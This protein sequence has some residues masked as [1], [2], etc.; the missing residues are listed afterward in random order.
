MNDKSSESEPS[1]GGRDRVVHLLFTTIAI[2]VVFLLLFIFEIKTSFFESLYFSN[3]SR[4]CSFSLGNGPSSSI[5]FPQTG[6]YDKRLGYTLIPDFIKRLKPYGFSIELQARI[7]QEMAKIFDE[8]LNMPYEEKQQAGIEVLDRK[9]KNLFLFK[10]PNPQLTSFDSIPEMIVKALLFIEDRN[11]LDSTHSH[12]NPAMNWTRFYYAMISFVESK[13]HLKKTV[14]G[15]STLA[16]QMEKYRHS[17]KGRTENVKDKLQQMLSASLLAYRDGAYTLPMRKSILLDYINTA[18][19]GARPAFGEVFG[20]SEG[21]SHWYKVRF[22][23]INA[24]LRGDSAPLIDQANAFRMVLGL[25]LAHRK[26]EYFLVKNST[27]LSEETDCY[28]RLFRQR[29]LF[30]DSLLGAAIAAGT[31]HR[32][33]FSAETHP[34]K[35]ILLKPANTVL[36]P[37]IKKLRLKDIYDLVHLDCSVES[38]LDSAAVTQVMTLFQQLKSRPELLDSLGLRAAHLLDLGNPADVIYSLVLFERKDNTNVVRIQADSHDAP[39]DFNSG[40]K[41]DLGS[42]AKLR[43]L[44]TY[45]EIIEELYYRHSR[46]DSVPSASDPLNDP[47]ASWV[48]A[49]LKRNPAASCIDILD[50]SLNRLYSANPYEKFFT[51]GGLHHFD[52]FDKQDD[53]RILSVREAFAHSVNLVFIRLMRDI[54]NHYVALLPDYESAEHDSAEIAKNHYLDLFIKYESVNLLGNFYRQLKKIPASEMADTLVDEI[55]SS[56]SRLGV[57][58]CTVAVDPSD[59]GMKEFF[60]RHGIVDTSM[61]FI[62]RLYSQC[63][64]FDWADRGY[65]AK[66]HPLK[67]WAASCLVK[68]P[69][70]NFS[71]LKSSCIPYLYEMYKWIFS[72]ERIAFQ[73]SRI[74]IMQEMEAFDALLRSWQKLGYPF[75]EIT[76]SFASAIGASADRPSA[77]A[78]LAGIIQNDGLKCPEKRIEKIR[79]AGQTPYET[80][81][82]NADT[83]SCERVL[84]PEVADRVR[85]CMFDV[86][87]DGTAVYASRS[88]DSSIIVGGK[89]GTGDHR[90]RFF[91]RFGVQ[92]GEKVVDRAATFV[93]IIDRRFFGTITVAVLGENAKDYDFTSAYPVRLFSLIAPKLVSFLQEK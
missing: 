26:P 73:K 11:L 68:N 69:K 62:T 44:V 48:T 12:M 27:A 75:A 90:M 61:A 72:P 79:F 57:I 28:L 63:K 22:E 19:L 20:L 89:T 82:I 70:T 41:L 64:A 6:P 2:I 86:I 29:G 5:R 9:N 15:A 51:G 53:G 67:L 3:R 84:S 31:Q 18:P 56:P 65:L 25:L 33:V 87:K 54:V 74:R 42:T 14:P 49:F 80:V 85:S 13:F 40:V 55:K 43:T 88:F 50:S 78:Q 52:N 38:T 4:A 59:T 34:P 39:L 77:L 16:T 91:N 37:L 36:D 23:S 8:G 76:P 71:D 24:A 7:S 83:T 10:S 17:A 60:K 45:L 30:S 66:V 35:N 46:Q 32:T 93:F 47:L 1:G 58:Y 21:I 92:T 81:M